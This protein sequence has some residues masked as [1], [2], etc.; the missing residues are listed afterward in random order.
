MAPHTTFN[1]WM[2]TRMPEGR[3]PAVILSSSRTRRASRST[4]SNRMTLNTRSMAAPS[5]KIPKDSP[6]AK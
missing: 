5:N 6:A 2:A 4:K 3:V 1:T